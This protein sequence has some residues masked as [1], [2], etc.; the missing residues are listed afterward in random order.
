MPVLTLW[1]AAIDCI[2]APVRTSLGARRAQRAHRPNE[3]FQFHRLLDHGIEAK[4]FS[5]FDEAGGR[6]NH[7]SGNGAE[8]RVGAHHAQ[9]VGSPSSAA[10]SGPQ[11]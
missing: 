11:P 2:W 8:Q 6:C 3:T 10:S 1:Q 5:P 4:R 7:H 9:T